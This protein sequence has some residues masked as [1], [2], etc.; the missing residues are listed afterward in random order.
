MTN[1]EI[2]QL[3]E[4]AYE[5]TF[6]GSVELLMERNKEYMRSDFYKNT[7]VALPDLFQKYFMWKKS[8]D[9]TIETLIKSLNQVD[10]KVLTDKAADFA[11]EIVENEKVK[12]F[13]A[14]VLEKMDYKKLEELSQQL[15]KTINKVNQ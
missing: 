14:E 8:Q 7:K 15:N 6:L 2:Q 5:S 4:D 13:I 10:V 9:N 3:L 1:L 11:N 12:K